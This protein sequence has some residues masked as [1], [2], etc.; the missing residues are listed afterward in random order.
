M[1]DQIEPATDPL[2]LTRY[3]EATRRELYERLVR[4]QRIS[5]EEDAGPPEEAAAGEDLEPAP[6]FD[7]VASE[8]V[9]FHVFGRWFATWLDLDAPEGAPEHLRRELVRIQSSPA[10]PEG[11]LL[12]EV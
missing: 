7:P 1:R 2:D 6:V 5:P 8:L 12:F 10:S 9:V 4:L 3:T 11:I